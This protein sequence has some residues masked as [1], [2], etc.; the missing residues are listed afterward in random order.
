LTSEQLSALPNTAEIL[1]AGLDHHQ[2]GRLAE[3]TACYLEI[4]RDAPHHADALHL[5]G[6]VAQQQGDIPVAVQLIEA[7]I[8]INPQAAHYHNNLGNTYRL[9]GNRIAAMA[10]YRRAIALDPADIAIQHSLANLLAESG[11]FE[12]AASLYQRVL[13][14][15]PHLAEA[16]YN[17][18][19]LRKRLGNLPAAIACYRRAIALKADCPEFYFNLAVA[20][21]QGGFLRESAESY[22][23]VLALRPDD[24]EAHYSLG[25][26]LQELDELKLAVACYERALQIKPD[27]REAYSNLAVTCVELGE[28]RRAAELYAH[29]LQ[30][31]PNNAV[32]C[33]NLGV[34]Y[35]E[36]G[37]LKAAADLQR[38]ALLLNP[39]M[40]VAHNNLGVVLARQGD[41][42]GAL[43]CYRR[44]VA[45][46]P[47]YVMALCNIGVQLSNGGDLAGA[48]DYYQRAL[49]CNP[50]FA[51]A[52]FQLGI[53]HLLQG[54]FPVGWEEYESRWR[55]RQLRLAKR[56][57][58]Q[59]LWQGEPLEGAR[60]LLHAEQGLGDT[61]QFVRYVPLVAARGG[62]VILEVQAGLQ[63]LLDGTPGALEMVI[64]GQALPDF[65]WQC[66][67]LSLPRAFQTGLQTIPAD[68]PYLKADPVASEAWA[69][70][71]ARTGLRIGVAWGGSA[72]HPY[73]QYRSIPLA[74]LA[75]LMQVEG[76][77]FYSLQKG[78]AAKQLQAMPAGMKLI[79][80]D[81]LQTD[82]A[83]T[84]AIV[85]NLDLVIS[86]DT[87]VAHLAGAMG[88][89]V[90]ILLHCV[91]DW[92]WLLNREDSPW[93]PTAR[94]F[95]QSAPG[96]WQ[97]VVNRL[98]RELQI[99]VKS[100]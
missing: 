50:E 8:Q 24:A 70:R 32:V 11:K 54:N 91:P 20:L 17:F 82:F 97:D 37:D 44:A 62:K 4:V 60:I 9:L 94:L 61:M 57:F 28:L 87:S 80:L 36:L 21:H 1:Q 73:E 16:H 45:L 42:A 59:P 79:D 76:V 90:W 51:T 92:R 26:V 6:I 41:S 53:V 49:E 93:Y 85:A 34:V 71:L 95:R 96:Q 99:L 40:A 19:N 78:P 63:R 86:I 38:R 88:K 81:A 75:P 84:A 58:S 65:D 74:Q 66:P 27:Y 67:L 2:A 56:K 23:Q 98:E 13:N 15:E 7:A 14:L 69:Q 64:R 3:A 30:L 5:L 22:R 68:A 39:E 18:G 72:T 25:V 12:E 77:T 43:S 29:R 10:S 100:R 83:D 31:E 46:K 89:P 48:A 55:A 52:R 35:K 47:D 33:S